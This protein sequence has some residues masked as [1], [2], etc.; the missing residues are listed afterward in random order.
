MD[1]TIILHPWEDGEGYTVT[2][3]AL[4]GCITQGYSKEEAIT[5]AKEAILCHLEGLKKAGEP[6]PIES[7]PSELM[8]LTV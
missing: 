5:N 2:I 3:P 8:R 6:I 7:K 1:Y 4:P